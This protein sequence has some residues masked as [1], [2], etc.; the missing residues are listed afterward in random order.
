M[1]QYYMHRK[2]NDVCVYINI[3]SKIVVEE[4][5][6][7]PPCEKSKKNHRAIV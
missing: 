1:G 7:D 3:K 6:K 2:R 5:K 4:I